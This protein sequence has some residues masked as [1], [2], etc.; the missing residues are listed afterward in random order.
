LD[1]NTSAGRGGGME[2]AS[3]QDASKVAIVRSGGPGLITAI[4]GCVL[5]ILGIFS[6]AIIFVP[7][8]AQYSLIGLV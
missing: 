2:L 6:V 4:L 8:A 7:M 1:R 5:G 3:N